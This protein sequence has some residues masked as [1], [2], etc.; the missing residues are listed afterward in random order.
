VQRKGPGTRGAGSS[1]RPRAAEGAILPL[2]LGLAGVLGAW[3]AGTARAAEGLDRLVAEGLAANR[4]LRQERLALQGSEA[5]VREALGQYLPSVSLNAR[6]S[7]RSGNITD[8]GKLINPA[9]GALNRLMGQA[10]FPTDITMK[11]PTRE[12]ASLRLTQPLI[13]PHIPAAWQ[14]RA[15]LRDAQRGAVAGAERNLAAGIRLGYLQYAKALRLVE[16][17]DSTLIL[18]GEVTRVQEA[19]LDNGQATP[20]QVLRAR[21]DQS[22]MEQRKLDAARLADAARQSLNVLLGRPVDAP[23]EQ[24]TDRQLGLELSVPLDSALALAQ[25]GRA[26]LIQARGGVRAARGQQAL[27]GAGYLPSL[28]GVVDWGVQGEKVDLKG[29]D[30][31]LVASLVL[32]WSL[33]DGGQREA[34]RQE[35]RAEAERARS[36]Q[37]DAA[38]QIALEVRTGWE[39]A[40]VARASLGSAQDRLSAARRTFELVARR[41]ANG[42]ASLLELLDARTSYTDA[43]LNEIFSTY[44]YWQRCAEFDRAAALYPPAGLEPAGR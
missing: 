44:D 10:A 2:I 14:I 43:G 20:D 24:L 12:E 41:H 1:K 40:R 6:I 21:A 13:E 11:L 32:Q 33:F 42:A 36:M 17:Y 9:F 15:G 37:A 39:A 30:D 8:V 7:D 26:E 3:P 25:A 4:G 16:L 35:A 29:N 38:E 27:A 23:L 28:I 19:L 31:Y 34:R 18:V 5:A 22:E